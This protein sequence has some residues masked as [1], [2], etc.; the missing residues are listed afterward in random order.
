MTE[1]VNPGGAPQPE[2]PQPDTPEVPGPQ[3]PDPD[4]QPP[5]PSTET[6]GPAEAGAPATANRQ[7]HSAD[8][9][10][11][12]TPPQAADDQQNADGEQGA[13]SAQS[14]GGE[15]SPGEPGADGEHS[16]DGEPR[17]GDEDE[18]ARSGIAISEPGKLLR[19]GTMAKQLL[20][21]VRSMELD[22]AARARLA[23]IHRR[24]VEELAVGMSDELVDELK[25]LNMPVTGDSAPSYG[26]LR[27]AQAQLVGWLEGLFHGIQTAI[28]AQQTL[29]Q[30]GGQAGQLPPGMTVVS[31]EAA[32]ERAQRPSGDEGHPGP[33]NYL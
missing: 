2:N 20:E 1:P 5:E 3:V 8:S 12:Q 25:R 17:S 14:A 27:L 9:D 26:E 33:G 15:Q 24:T 10:E 16:A 29:A 6:G 30:Q 19:V 32:Q 11:Q 4:V 7:E 22:E 13:R 18:D 21:E 23:E 28:M 31:P